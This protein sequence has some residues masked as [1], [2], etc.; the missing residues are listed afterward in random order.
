MDAV[1]KAMQ[2]AATPAALAADTKVV[3]HVAMSAAAYGVAQQAAASV[4]AQQAAVAF[5][6]VAA[7]DS[8]AVA[9]AAGAAVDAGKRHIDRCCQRSHLPKTRGGWDFWRLDTE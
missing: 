7:E 2:P 3:S 5:A 4:V 8:A 9:A 1:V 6:A